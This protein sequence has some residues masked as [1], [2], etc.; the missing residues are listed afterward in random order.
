MKIKQFI[1]F[2]LLLF[3]G[4]IKNSE[5]DMPYCQQRHKRNF[6]VSHCRDFHLYPLS[7]GE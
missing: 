7:A 2:T 3:R 1:V 6:A 5:D 4:V